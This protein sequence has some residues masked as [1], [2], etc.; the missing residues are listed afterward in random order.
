MAYYLMALRQLRQERF[1]DSQRPADIHIPL[2]SRHIIAAPAVALA[3]VLGAGS[4]KALDDETVRLQDFVR[5]FMR[6]SVAKFTLQMPAWIH[7]R[8]ASSVSPEAPCSTR[9]AF[10]SP[11]N[12]LTNGTFN[13]SSW[14]TIRKSA[15][16]TLPIA[17]SIT[18]VFTSMQEVKS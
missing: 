6:S 16:Q 10:T 12:S 11:A 9:G 4:G 7:S 15:N 18:Q 1:H 8:T 14:P 3:I 13:L 5:S 17:I 2:T